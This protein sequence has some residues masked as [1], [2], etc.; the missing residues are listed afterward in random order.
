MSKKLVTISIEDWTE[1]FKPVKNYISKFNGNEP[2]YDGCMFETSGEEEAYVKII[3]A[4]QPLKVWTVLDCDGSL[5]VSQGYHHVNR[6][7]YLIT[8]KCA[9]TDTEYLI[10]DDMNDVIQDSSILEVAHISV[11]ELVDEYDDP[12][13]VPEWI[14]IKQ[15]AS[16]GHVK[17]GKHGIY[18][19]ALNMS[20]AFDDIP[21]A[22]HQVIN[23]A[24]RKNIAYLIFH[25]DT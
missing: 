11:P 3:N 21:D 24:K 8:E 15:N 7:G 2:A 1:Q 12:D 25:Q 20:I 18:E 4:E 14:W 16:Y 5:I 6:F 17:N 19:F 13:D 23:E 22:L 10:Q 9:E